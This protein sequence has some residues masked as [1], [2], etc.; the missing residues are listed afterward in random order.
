MRPQV[1]AALAGCA[2]GAL[3][4][5]PV[6]HL[7]IHAY[8]L[9]S[10]VLPVPTGV[11]WKAMAEVAAR[12]S[13][14]LPPGALPAVACSAAL[15]ALLAALGSTRLGRWLPSAFAMGIGVLVPVNYSAAIVLGALALTAGERLRPGFRRESGPVA[16]AGLIAG[17][18]V[19]GLVVALLTSFALL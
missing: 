12:G 5:M 10:P 6:Y 14:A 17:D 1:L 2:V 15:G 3:V 11:Q 19:V 9:G 13:D 4:C 18:S 7:L 16:G 8:G